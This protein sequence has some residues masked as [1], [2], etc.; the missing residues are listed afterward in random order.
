MRSRFPNASERFD[1]VVDQHAVPRVDHFAFNRRI[2][3]R[4][5]HHQRKRNHSNQQFPPQPQIC[6]EAHPN[7]L[8]P[9]LD[10]NL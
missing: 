9:L 2:D 4:Y 7:A 8:Q 10:L 3:A 6:K 5:H 1:L